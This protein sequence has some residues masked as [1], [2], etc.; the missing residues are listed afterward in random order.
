MTAYKANWFSV[1]TDI[2]SFITTFVVGTE[3]FK[4]TKVTESDF[5]I[6]NITIPNTPIIVYELTRGKVITYVTTGNW[7]SCLLQF[8]KAS[9]VDEVNENQQYWNY[10]VGV[11]P[12]IEELDY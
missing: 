1:L 7:E 10:T 3:T 5:I 9:A 6:E 12:S 2:N 8:G 11:T 4:I